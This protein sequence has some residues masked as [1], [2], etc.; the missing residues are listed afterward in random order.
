M[1]ASVFAGLGR[2]YLKNQDLIVGR[3]L[4]GMGYQLFFMCKYLSILSPKTKL[5]H[6]LK[7]Y[8]MMFGRD[9]GAFGNHFAWISHLCLLNQFLAHLLSVMSTP[10]SY[11]TPFLIIN[12]TTT[13]RNESSLLND[14]S[15]RF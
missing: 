5:K 7:E 8:I 9:T 14:I 13:I 12:Y 4:S 1:E 15:I 11:Q 6:W 10:R 3:F 2:I